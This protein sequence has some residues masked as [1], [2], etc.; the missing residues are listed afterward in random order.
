M[1]K[2]EIIRDYQGLVMKIA[3]KWTGRGVDFLDLVQEGNLGL[4]AAFDRFDTTRGVKFITYAT[5]WVN[6]YIREA[7]LT[8][9]NIVRLPLHVQRSAHQEREKARKIEM[10]YGYTITVGCVK[11]PIAVVL[12]E[13]MIASPTTHD[14]LL[15][16]ILEAVPVLTWAEAIIVRFR[17]VDGLTLA[18]CGNAL[19]YTKSR[20]QQ[21][22]KGALSKLRKRISANRRCP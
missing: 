14:P 12:D 22:E 7:A 2:D 3:R 20:A 4:L 10:Q 6:K 1:T 9:G 17:Y 15:E 21:I 8:S 19:K 16:D 18:E 11:D 5:P 13:G